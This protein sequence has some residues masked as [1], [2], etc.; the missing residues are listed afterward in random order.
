[1]RPWLLPAYEYEWPDALAAS[2]AVKIRFV[3]GYGAAAAV[4]DDLKAWLLLAIG[5]LYTYRETL[6]AG[7][8]V[9]LPGG[10]WQS[11]LD[12]YRTFAF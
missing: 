1:M 7:Q 12:P 6:A 3:A 8:V 2:N 11:L 5:T 10:F 9:E 4:P